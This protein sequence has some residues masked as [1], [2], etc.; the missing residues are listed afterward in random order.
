M[1][2]PLCIRAIEDTTQNGKAILKF[3]SRNDVGLTGGHQC[4]YYLPKAVWQMFTTHP[5]VK[6]E[7]AESTVTVQ[8]QGGR[9]TTE[10]HVKWYGKNTRSEYRLTSFGLR[11]PWI[12]HQNVGNLL[13]LIPKNHKEFIAYV[14]DR[15]ED[16]EEIRATLGLE[17]FERWGAYEGGSPKVGT[18]DECIERHFQEFAEHLTDF[19]DGL[20][21]SAAA[22]QTLLECKGTFHSS[23]IDDQLMDCVDVEYKLF[24]RVERKLCGSEITRPFRDVDDFV[25]T[26]SRLL[27]R[28]KSR[29]G[30]SLENH[31]DY[32]LSQAQIPHMM[33]PAG[34]DGRPDIVIP[35]Q[36]AYHSSSYP[37]NKVFI[38]GVKTTCKDR[39][40]QVLNEGTKVPTKYILTI[41]PGISSKQ[42]REMHRAN[43]TLVVPKRLHRDYPS[44]RAVTLLNMQEFIDSIRSKLN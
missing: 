27:N 20:T 30:R 22:R 35:S 43:V 1:P 8:W 32:L 42:L 41:Q 37:I 28:R 29:A 23:T 24:R 17:T 33:R 16:I 2:S 14:F 38:I 5:P 3:I 19:P 31:V 12:T 21:F 10:S 15:D 18:E 26:A 39:W 34:I 40:R 6:G 25:Q 7:N 13:V 36:D 11:F 9:T 44:S 4:G